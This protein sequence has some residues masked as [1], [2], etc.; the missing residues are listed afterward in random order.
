[1]KPPRQKRAGSPISRRRPAPT[2]WAGSPCMWDIFSDISARAS[3]PS[4]RISSA[5]CLNTELT[6]SGTLRGVSSAD[7]I[8]V[9]LFR[10]DAGRSAGT[11]GER[12]GGVQQGGQ[13]HGLQLS[14]LCYAALAAILP[15]LLPGPRR[16]CLAG[17]PAA[18]TAQ[19]EA[20][21]E[22]GRLG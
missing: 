14:V 1:P 4:V 20:G 18:G 12:A 8:A 10:V 5:S 6:S 19:G 3:M 16:G 15:A 9:S 11:G 22:N 2:G 13:F 21:R 17:G 7:I